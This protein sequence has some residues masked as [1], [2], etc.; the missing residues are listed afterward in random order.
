MI[1]IA[2]RHAWPHRP[3]SIRLSFSLRAIVIQFFLPLLPAHA[4]PAARGASNHFLQFPPASQVSV[5]VRF[6]QTRLDKPAPARLCSICSG[7]SQIRLSHHWQKTWDPLPVY[8][9]HSWPKIKP[10]RPLRLP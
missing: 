10:K 3:S 1:D 7:G 5:E 6:M 4:Q 2:I 9:E 8:I